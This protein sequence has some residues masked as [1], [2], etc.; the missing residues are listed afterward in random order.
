[1]GRQKKAAKEKDAKEPEESGTYDGESVGNGRQWMKKFSRMKVGPPKG[2]KTVMGST[3]PGRRE[4]GMIEK[5]TSLRR[6]SRT[7]GV[8]V[9]KKDLNDI[10]SHM[11]SEPFLA[12]TQKYQQKL[13]TSTKKMRAQLR[14][15][16][17][18]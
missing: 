13:Q 16:R 8:E 9:K 11:N 3:N 14:K 6:L 18:S 12:D 4:T 1:V 15:M 10:M 5:A 2:V 7:V 17:G